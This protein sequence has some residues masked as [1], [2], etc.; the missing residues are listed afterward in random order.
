[1]AVF[2]PYP[3]GYV[4]VLE[5]GRR[6]GRLAAMK[7]ILIIL[8]FVVLTGFFAAGVA[9]AAKGSPLLLIISL[10]VYLAAFAKAGCLSQ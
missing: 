2:P 8:L 10:V 6:I 1:V 3:V 9:L 5:S 7:S 4:L